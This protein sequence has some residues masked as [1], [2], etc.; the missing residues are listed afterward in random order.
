MAV[1][2]APYLIPVLE[3]EDEIDTT[4]RVNGTIIGVEQAFNHIGCNG[5]TKRD[6]EIVAA[7]K[8]IC[9]SCKLPTATLSSCPIHWTLHIIVKPKSSFKSLRLRLDSNSTEALLQVIK[10]C[11]STWNSYRR[12]HHC[13][14]FGKVPNLSNFHL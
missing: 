6:V 10:V 8:A 11:I 14:D 1:N 2:T 3:Y 7:N 12:Y 5:C 4:S 9:Y 13:K